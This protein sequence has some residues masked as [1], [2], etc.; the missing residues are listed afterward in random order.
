MPTKTASKPAAKKAAAKKAPAKPTTKDLLLSAAKSAGEDGAS[1]NDLA[2]AAGVSA[3]TAKKALKALAD[4]GKLT[5][6]GDTVKA[7]QRVGR[8]SAD[9]IDRDEQILGLIAAAG[10][11]GISKADLAEKADTTERLTYESLWRL[12]EQGKV[13]RSGSTR[14]AVWV[15]A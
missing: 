5:V 7:K 9:V 15:A 2:T 10:A 6:D 8:R 12:R 11:D 1:I 3:S 4:E 14:S 13:S